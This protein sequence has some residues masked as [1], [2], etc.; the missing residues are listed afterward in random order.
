M[1][2]PAQKPLSFS[3]IVASWQRPDWLKRCLKSLTQ[4]DHED[5]EIVVVADAD[6]LAKTDGALIK[7]VLFET[8]NLSAARNAGISEA[9]GEVCAFIDDDAVAEPMWLRHLQS[10]FESQ[11]ADAVVGYVRGRNGFSYQSR[12]Q[13]IDAE[14]ETHTETV[15]SNEQPFTP[16]LTPERAVKLVGTN[17]AIRRDVLGKVGGFDEAFRYYL[18]DTDISLRLAKSGYKSAVA[19]MAQVHHAFAPSNRRTKLRTPKDLW[20]IGRSTAIYL[21]RHGKLD[22]KDI[23]TRIEKRER[24]RLLHH[25]VQGTCE[26]RDVLLKLKQLRDG[27]V[28]GWLTELSAHHSLPQGQSEFLKFPQ[29]PTGH[30]VFASRLLRRK[31]TVKQAEQHVQGGG[32]ATVISMSLTPVRHRLRYTD[33]GVWLQT[34]GQFG[35]SVREMPWLRWCNFRRRL[36]EEKNRVAKSRGIGDI[37]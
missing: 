6:G 18:D 25:M 30:N 29:D 15:E 9:A 37:A 36:A 27:F 33:T 14:A 12:F 7:R 21:R 2:D 8:P 28:E 24:N 22:H 31:R 5:F 4:L 1:T 19:P 23:Q 10:A 32:R 20:D 26:P 17:M 11:R 3:V 13:S 34:G 16:T 35:R